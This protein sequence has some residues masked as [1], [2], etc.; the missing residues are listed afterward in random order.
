MIIQKLLREEHSK[1]QTLKIIRYVGNDRKRYDTLVKI[2]LGNDK[3]LAQRASWPLRYCTEKYPDFAKKHLRKLIRK[4]KEPTHNA[5]RR[6]ILQM[7]CSISIPTSLDAQA[8]SICFKLLNDR[9]E[10]VASKVFSMTVLANYCQKYPELK[11]EL[12]ASIQSQLQ[13]ESP[14]FRSRAKKLSRMVGL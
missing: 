6:S 11:S 13:Y 8:I 9:S 12:K 2:C 3:L 7:L 14:A 1:H 4:L 10:F 5:I